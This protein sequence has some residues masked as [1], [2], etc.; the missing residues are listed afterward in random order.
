MDNIFRRNVT[1]TVYINSLT[2]TVHKFFAVYNLEFEPGTAD[3]ISEALPK[4]HLMSY[5]MRCHISFE[6]WDNIFTKINK[7]GS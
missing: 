1:C 3:K 6:D 2:L 4:S 5:I 7:F